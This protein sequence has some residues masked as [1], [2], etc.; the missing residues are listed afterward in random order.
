MQSK[1]TPSQTDAFALHEPLLLRQY[2]I[3]QATPCD[4]HH[5]CQ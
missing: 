5:S 4:G 3:L 1:R 2:H